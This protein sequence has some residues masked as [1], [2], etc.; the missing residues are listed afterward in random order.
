MLISPTVFQASPHP[1]PQLHPQTAY[2]FKEAM[3]LAVSHCELALILLTEDHPAREE[4]SQ[5]LTS[6]AL[7]CAI[8]REWAHLPYAP[9][10]V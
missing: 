9:T 1:V 6:A 5:A 4:V 2:D 10:P 7:A 3:Q 8:S